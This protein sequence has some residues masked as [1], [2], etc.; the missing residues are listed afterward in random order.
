MKELLTRALFGLIYVLI[1]VFSLQSPQATVL[2][3]AFFLFMSLVEF[4][5]LINQNHRLVLLPALIIYLLSY[6]FAGKL[7][8]NVIQVGMGFSI[9]VL[10][11]P[12][13]LFVF[14]KLS[15]EDIQKFYLSIVYLVLP[16]ALALNLSRNILL[17]IFILLWSSDSF[18]YLV[19]K[20]FGKHKLAEKISPKK[21]IEGLA[22]GWIGATIVSIL[23]YYYMNLNLS[24]MQI[25]ILATVVV[26]FGTIGDLI[27]SKFKR[28][29]SVK[30][31]GNIMPGHGGVLDRLDSFIFA[32]PFVYVLI[33]FF[34]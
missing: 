9:L 11:V 3:L 19:G 21:T 24:L 22:G 20:Y 33:T 14:E 28:L 34:N 30:D 18:A 5:K 10:F 25:L 26:V 12:L 15:K 32:T 4:S 16:F 17:T 27:E 7:N 31:S 1:V 29:A 8:I 23:I 13:A 6:M 2:L